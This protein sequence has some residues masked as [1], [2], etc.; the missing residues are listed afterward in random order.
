M[1]KNVP[2]QEPSAA[3]ND[4]NAP[5]FPTDRVDLV[6]NMRLVAEVATKVNSN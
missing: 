2:L 1:E 6:P 5:A 4:V 3:H